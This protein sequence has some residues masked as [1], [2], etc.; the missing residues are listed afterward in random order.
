[1][2][3]E[4]LEAARQA[5]AHGYS[6][7]PIKVDGTKRP[8]GRWKH[9]MTDPPTP[10]EV[11]ATF[12]GR[13]ALGLVCGTV[14]GN[15]E[16]LEFEG[17][18]LHLFPLYREAC[19]TAGIGE[20]LDQV[21]AG[22]A[23]E[24]PGG[25]LHL[26]YR[27]DRPVDGNQKLAR[28]PATD[29]ELAENPKEPVKVLIETRGEGGFVVVAPS[30]GGAHSTGKP[31]VLRRGGLD[32]VTTVTLEERNQLLTVAR[33][34]DQ[35]PVERPAPTKIQKSLNV[36]NGDS[37]MDAI[38]AAFNDATTW[39]QLL[40]PEGWTFSHRSA[41]VDH[42]TRP[43]KQ[44]KDGHSATVNA[45]GTDR[46]IVHSSSVAGFELSPT[47]YDRFGAW[48]ILHHGGDRQAAALAARADGHGPPLE[49]LVLV[50]EDGLAVLAGGEGAGEWPDPRPFGVTIA[51][52]PRFPLDTLPSWMTRQVDD[53]ARQL[54]V[55]VD[56]PALLAIGALATVVAGKARLTVADGWVEQL[57]L[58]LAVAMPP[59]SGKS[60]AA[61]A[62][63][64]P[65]EELEAELVASHK[66]AA[67]E[68]AQR[69]KIAEKR[70][71][72]L[73]TKA[74]KTGEPVDIDAAVRAFLDV[75]NHETPA[76]PR[77]LS[78]DATPEA[79]TAV[80]ATNGG[81]ITIASTEGGLFELM[82]GRYSDGRANLDVYLKAWSSDSIRVDRIGRPPIHIPHPIV[83]VALAVQPDVLRAL[84]DR[85]ELAGRGLTARFMYAL[86]TDL[87][88]RRDLTK[89]RDHNALVRL[90]YSEQLITIGRRYAH[91]LMPADLRLAPDAAAHYG[92]WRQTLEARRTPDGDLRHVAEWTGK[93]EG[94][95]LRVAGLLH[96]AD[97]QAANQPVDHPTLRR[98]IAIGDYW[99]Q[100]ALT[101]HRMWR[102]DRAVDDAHTIITWALEYTDGTFSRR[103][104]AAALNRF[105]DDPPLTAALQA[106]VD[107]DWMRTDDG[108]PIE[109]RRG[110]GK[111]GQRYLLH[112]Y[113]RTLLN[114]LNGRTD[115]EEVENA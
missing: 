94:T 76:S 53:V 90:G 30:N 111:T 10:A 106:L 32:Q 7:I 98:A 12:A 97:G 39:P 69:K 20:V 59:S 88:G 17:R 78:D 50:D 101:I 61:K 21:I 33:T 81:R 96:I 108:E 112:P 23:E 11:D 104:I 5:I 77:L 57:N 49:D 75:D 92:M 41:E 87:V 55:P 14:S 48:A 80:L 73:E 47:S 27:C 13:D 40:E 34:F 105:R 1:M 42:W 31:W 63:L 95:V 18:A 64:A 46:L 83:T 9:R 114:G 74:A 68:A 24:T 35:M 102:E 44:T 113:A 115:P 19:A 89:P 72:D 109:V 28:R 93:L 62:M 70:A 4:I 51:N 36:G 43:G 100:H 85:P 71:K 29:D 60:P 37:W 86:P 45:T 65:V 107:H 67:A 26:L 25:G 54:Q 2:N 6:P 99:L 16:L 79:L 58:Y 84:A 103:D 15:L 110:R 91:A 38:A 8:N 22:Y 3:A 82:T 56:L 52:L 66:T